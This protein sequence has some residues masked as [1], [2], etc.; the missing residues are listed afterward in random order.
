MPEEAKE[1]FAEDCL[2]VPPETPS[3][4]LARDH[5]LSGLLPQARFAPRNQLFSW[6]PVIVHNRP[7]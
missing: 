1:E 3:W 4:C 6:G 5:Y 7:P 2:K